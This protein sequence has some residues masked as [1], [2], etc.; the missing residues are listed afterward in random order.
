MA[1]LKLH[2]QDIIAPTKR[3]QSGGS[4]TYAAAEELESPI[5]T[6]TLVDP[7]AEFCQLLISD[8]REGANADEM[9]GGMGTYLIRSCVERIQKAGVRLSR[10]LDKLFG[11]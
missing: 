2:R 3:P 10:L 7:S 5:S 8:E 9:Q 6:V 1:A 11:E 4:K